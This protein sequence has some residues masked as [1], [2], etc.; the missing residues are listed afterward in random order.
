[1]TF[2]IVFQRPR[3]ERG[4][5][6]NVFQGS[7]E[8]KCFFFLIIFQMLTRERG[9]DKKKIFKGPLKKWFYL[10]SFSKAWKGKWILYFFSRVR[11]KEKEGKLGFNK[12]IVQGSKSQ[13]GSE[14]YNFF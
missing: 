3:S 13:K 11:R 10:N 12:N 4:F 6:E 9:F 8:K 14:F 1:M 2:L 7:V 5:Y